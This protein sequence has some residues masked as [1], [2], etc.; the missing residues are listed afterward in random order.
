MRRDS[1]YRI[2]PI[3]ALGFFAAATSWLDRIAQPPGDGS[4]RPASSSPDMLVD[5][6]TLRRFNPAG[7][8][9]FIFRATA[10][11]HYAAPERTELEMP[12]LLFLGSAAPMAARAMKGTVSADGE[13]VHLQGEVVVT[14]DAHPGHP[15][16]VLRT[17]AMTIWPE[18]EQVAGDVTVHYE[19]GPNRLTAGN[20]RADNLNDTLQLGGGVAATVHR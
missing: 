19:A 4:A 11:R 6:F 12:R 17:E 9:Q 7:E 5:A 18:T 10:M 15:E 16:A 20:F 13:A 8:Q 2:Y 3:V 1:L 14:R